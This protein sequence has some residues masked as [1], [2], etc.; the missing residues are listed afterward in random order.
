[1]SRRDDNDDDP[2][3]EGPTTTE[4]QVLRAAARGLSAA[5]NRGS[6][7]IKSQIEVETE[8]PGGGEAA[9]AFGG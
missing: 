7:I 2:N 3:G 8:R 9:R 1:M 5:A 6:E 4:R